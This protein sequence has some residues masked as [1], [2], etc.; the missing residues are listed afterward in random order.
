M[1]TVFGFLSI[2]VGCGRHFDGLLSPAEHPLSSSIERKAAGGAG[3]NWSSDV[4]SWA[5]PFPGSEV[6]LKWVST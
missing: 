3:G 5:A 2:F 6:S 4:F 1:F